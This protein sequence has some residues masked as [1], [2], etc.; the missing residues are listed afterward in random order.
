M[1]GIRQR[2]NGTWEFKFQRKGLLPSPVHFTF[3]TLEEGEAYAARVEGLFDRGIVPAE[4]TGVAIRT[5]ADLC[6]HYEALATCSKSDQDVLK[7][8][9]KALESTAVTRLSYEWVEGWVTTMKASLRPST[10]KKRVGLLGRVIDWC[11]R[12]NLITLATNPV[13]LLPRGYATLGVARHERWSGERDR[14]LEGDEEARIRKVLKTPEEHLLFDMAL[15]SAMR[16]SEMLTLTLA[17]VDLPRRT[18]FLDRTKNGSKRQ[19]PI[20]STLLKLLDSHLKTLP[21]GTEHLFS[22]GTLPVATARNRLSHLY[23]T[24][25][26]KAGCPDLR[27]HDLRHE[28]TARFFERTTLSDTE[29]AMITGHKDPRMLKRYA[30]LRAS[31]LASKLW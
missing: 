7:P 26:A 1:A 15:E 25:F 27:Y 2:Q 9:T 31:T 28:A 13:K 4:F 21:E 8:L 11:L 23:A 19:V 17:Q 29:I 30:N 3:D 22:W 24:R 14:R 12:R 6:R 10:L 16:L 18:I 20:S 5:L